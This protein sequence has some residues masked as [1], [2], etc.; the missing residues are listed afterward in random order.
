MKQTV[1]ILGASDKPDRF[2]YKAFQM[3]KQYGHNPIP[4]GKNLKTLEGRT[5]YEKLADIPTPVETLTMYVRPEVSSSMQDE[6]LKLKP[7]RVIFNPNTEN[8][9]LVKALEKAGIHT[10]EACTLVL[11]GAGQFETA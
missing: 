8:P 11:L 5:V 4:V 9:E 3:L 2:A 6:I 10:V 1:A 7:K